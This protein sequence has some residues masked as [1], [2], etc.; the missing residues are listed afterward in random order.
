MYYLGAN[1]EPIAT[2]GADKMQPPALQSRLHATP[3]SAL[4]CALLQ[5]PNGVGDVIIASFSIKER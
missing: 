5:L 4:L 3:Q 1:F 2:L